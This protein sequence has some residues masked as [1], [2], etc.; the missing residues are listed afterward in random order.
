[1]W[2]WWKVLN[3]W[4]PMKSLHGQYRH[5]S[6]L[7][8]VT[9]GMSFVSPVWFTPPHWDSTFFKGLLVVGAH[10]VFSLVVL[11]PMD[12]G[13]HGGWWATRISRRRWIVGGIHGCRVASDISIFLDL[14][15][16]M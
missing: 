14:R 13:H 12:L 8:S 1:M 3:F 10:M 11:V 15:G 16:F 7:L 5:L 4:P 2:F 6:Q 9:M